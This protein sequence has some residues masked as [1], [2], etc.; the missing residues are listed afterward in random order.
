MRAGS[1][2]Y[3]CGIITAMRAGSIETGAYVFMLPDN[4]R[5]A[6]G[7]SVKIPPSMQA[8]ENGGA[9]IAS[10]Y[11][12]YISAALLNFTDYVG[13]T[14]LDTDGPYGGSP[15][16]S[17]NH[18]HHHGRGDSVYMQEKYQGLFYER[19]VAKGF[20][21]HVPDNY[22][23]QGSSMTGMGY[24]EQQFSLAGADREP[25]DPVRRHVQSAPD[26]G[27][28]AHPA[29]AV[30]CR[31][32]RCHH[33]RACQRLQ[34]GP[35]AVLLCWDGQHADRR[36]RT[37]LHHGDACCPRMLNTRGVSFFDDL[38]KYI[39][40]RIL[41]RETCILLLEPCI[42]FTDPPVF[43]ILGAVVTGWT[44][45]Y[46][47]HRQTLIQPL[48][49]LRRANGQGW[50]GWLH[51]NSRALRAPGGQRARGVDTA[52]GA[53]SAAQS[54]E[55][56]VAVVFN[57]TDLVEVIAFPLYYTGVSGLSVLVSMNEGTPAAHT[58]ERDYYLLLKV[59]ISPNNMTTLV[60][61]APIDTLR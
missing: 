27:L 15:C 22:F 40:T 35:R 58:V 52:A 44:R 4:Y 49:H 5:D 43:S 13:L 34:L 2:I 61:S 42:V 10:A 30:P 28:D 26:P 45:F 56:G 7:R 55:V 19:L 53:S 1:A 20:Y 57:P 31:R 9:C 29:G 16:S 39:Y 18:S 37:V 3:A 47:A 59:T 50:D 38:K 51:A 46:K 36:P 32:G 6:S 8:T 48:I 54:I 12:D 24:N 23:F 41:V 21:L 33:G 11:Y 17:T 60:F 14:M 25:R